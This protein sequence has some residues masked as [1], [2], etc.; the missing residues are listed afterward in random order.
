MAAELDCLFLHL[1]ALKSEQISGVPSTAIVSAAGV[2]RTE[3]MRTV[4]AVCP[5]KIG[6]T[7]A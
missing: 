3:V 2:E 4:H 1:T 6:W 7:L 5:Q